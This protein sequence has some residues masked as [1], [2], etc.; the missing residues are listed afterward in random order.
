[1]S[2]EE[3]RPR[4]AGREPKRLE[5]AAL[6]AAL[7]APTRA[8]LE[9]AAAAY[10]QELRDAVAAGALG[11]Y[12]R[13]FVQAGMPHTDP[14]TSQHV[15][16][17]GALTLTM[18]SPAIVGLPYGSIPRL[19]LSWVTTEAVR[20]KE[21]RLLL[22]NTLRSFMDQLGLSST[23]GRRGDIT[24]LRNQMRR[25]FASSINCTYEGPAGWAMANVN[26]ADQAELWWDPKHPDQADLWDSTVVL[27]ERFFEEVIKRPVPIDTRALRALTRSPLAI[28]LYVWLTHRMSYLQAPTTIPWELLALQTGAHYREVRQFRRRALKALPKVAAVYPAARVKPAVDHHGRPLGLKLEPSPTHVRHRPRASS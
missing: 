1:V 21:R 3:Q 4:G 26:V 19:L 10:E 2:G 7:P 18:M 22:G 11:F 17:N 15:R 25:L 20:T 12:A 24:R 5:Q 8:N 27:G 16:S 28:D 9:L 6:I 14:H 13:L 23:G